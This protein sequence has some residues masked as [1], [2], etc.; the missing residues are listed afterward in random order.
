MHKF[1]LYKTPFSNLHFIK[2]EELKSK[3]EILTIEPGSLL[4]S[5]IFCYQVIGL[6]LLLFIILI[7]NGNFPRIKLIQLPDQNRFRS[8]N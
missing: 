1:H 6:K 3:S 2:T 5:L 4:I 7:L 8:K